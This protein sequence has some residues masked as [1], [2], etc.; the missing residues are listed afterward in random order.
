MKPRTREARE[1][2]ENTAIDP[3]ETITSHDVNNWYTN[4]PLKV[5]VEQPPSEI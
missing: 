3:D 1:T 5:A 4:A 2:I